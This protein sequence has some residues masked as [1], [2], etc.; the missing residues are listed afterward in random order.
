[1][2]INTKTIEILV[3]GFECEDDLYCAA[4]G[5]AMGLQTKYRSSLVPVIVKNASDDFFGNS[6]DIIFK[7]HDLSGKDKL[8]IN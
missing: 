3:S 2:R 1:M 8:K 4:I 5:A 7:Y 6:Y